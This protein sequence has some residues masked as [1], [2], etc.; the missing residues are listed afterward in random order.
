MLF[1]NF[2][3]GAGMFPDLLLISNPNTIA[4]SAQFVRKTSDLGLI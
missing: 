4:V 2:M 3:Q 1:H